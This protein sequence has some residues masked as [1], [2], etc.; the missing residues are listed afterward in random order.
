MAVILQ[1]SETKFFGEGQES[2]FFGEGTSLAEAGDR[3]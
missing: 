2:A 1:R 3:C